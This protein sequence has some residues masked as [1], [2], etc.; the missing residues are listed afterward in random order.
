MDSDVPSLQGHRCT[1]V[2]SGDIQKPGNKLS[3][4]TGP[5]QS[6]SS[7]HRHS[8]MAVLVPR[9]IIRMEI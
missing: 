6:A 5:A 1:H 4:G 3:P 7:G 8:V 2:K 9:C